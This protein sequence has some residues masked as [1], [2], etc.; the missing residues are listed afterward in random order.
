M[1]LEPVTRIVWD[2]LLGVAHVRRRHIAKESG[3][4]QSDSLL[5]LSSYEKH[6]GARMKHWNANRATDAKGRHVF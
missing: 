5:A 4:S 2:D 1:G 3:R 6:S